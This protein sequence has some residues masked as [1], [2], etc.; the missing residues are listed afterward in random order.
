MVSGK[1]FRSSLR[2][3]LPGTKKQKKC[4][5]VPAFTIQA[6]QN[7]T[8]VLPP[9]KCSF[10]EKPTKVFKFQDNYKRGNL[11]IA[12]QAVGNG[13]VW[14]A[15]ITKLDFHYYL[16]M[17]FE[18]LVETEDPYK[19]F[20]HQ[21][22]HDMLIQGG[23]KAFPC[24]PQ[25][26]IPIKDALNTRNKSIMIATLKVVQELVT[27]ADMIGE[28]LVP[29][30]RQLLPVLNIYKDKNVN[31]GGDIDYSQAR[32]DNLGDVVN[33]T[34]EILERTGGEDAF[35]NIKYLIPT[36]ESCMLN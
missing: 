35:I 14:K 27:C 16:P 30:Y 26:I 20:A 13:L 9:A 11:P 1:E 25:L 23:S 28:A 7:N 17:F 10:K 32:G 31:C 33:E 21:A 29:Y 36:Y 2:K 24:I 5:I 6:M 3:P 18:G 12:K 4:R 15:D 8:C 22:I 34:L 19:L